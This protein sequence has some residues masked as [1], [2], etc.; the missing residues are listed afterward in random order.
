MDEDSW[1]MQ[2]FDEWYYHNQK[3][4][5]ESGKE[6]ASGSWFEAFLS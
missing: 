1:N 4:Y 3:K 5:I 6:I 2:A